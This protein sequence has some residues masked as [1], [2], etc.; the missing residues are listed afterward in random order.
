MASMP[1]EKHLLVGLID[2]K[3]VTPQK[4]TPKK[5][6]SEKVVEELEESSKIESSLKI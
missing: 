2:D 4:K 3:V 1:D 6:P 5:S